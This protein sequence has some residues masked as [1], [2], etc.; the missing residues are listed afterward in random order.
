MIIEFLNFNDEQINAVNINL[1]SNGEVSIFVRVTCEVGYFLGAEPADVDILA[2]EIN[3]NSFVDIITNPIDLSP[4]AGQY[5]DYH[6]KFVSGTV[7]N[8][9]FQNYNIFISKL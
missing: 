1:P 4:F 2:S 8:L 7:T 6:I 9:Q 5:K 3:V